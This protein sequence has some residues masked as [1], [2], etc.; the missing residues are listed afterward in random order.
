MKKLL[1]L[2]LCVMLFVSVIPTSA[3]A[4]TSV[5]GDG[6]AAK[7]ADDLSPNF[8]SVAT[9]KKAITNLGKDINAM[10]TA[11]AADQTVFGTAKTIYDMTDA[12][13]KDLLKGVGS[14]KDPRTG[15]TIYEDDLA[16]NVRKSLNKILGNQITNYMNDRTSMFLD[17][18]GYVKPDKYLK[19]WGD[20][21]KNALSSEKAQKN[22]E[23]IVTGLFAMKVQKAVNDGADDLY[24]EIVEW[25]NWG[26]FNWGTLIKPYT[27]TAGSQGN[28]DVYTAWNPVANSDGDNTAL[29]STGLNND[30]LNI[31]GTWF[32]GNAGI[33]AGALFNS[34]S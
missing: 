32:D 27:R 3:F 7:N 17:S 1:A 11:L 25:D 22:I 12:L 28:I 34:L 2:I 13:S 10:Y 16:G 20:A 6:T 14:V 29:I 23:A 9:A 4:Y 30:F 19:V 31:N 15:A 8:K 24:D 21:V 33:A 5:S 18:N 26:E